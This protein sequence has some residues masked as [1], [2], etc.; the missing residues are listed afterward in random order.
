MSQQIDTPKV[1][2]SEYREASQTNVQIANERECVIQ[3]S[4]T[5]IEVKL[6]NISATDKIRRDFFYDYQ[7]TFFNMRNKLRFNKD[8]DTKIYDPIS[9]GYHFLDKLSDM[10]LDWYDSRVNSSF[11]RHY[12]DCQAKPHSIL[13]I[14]ETLYHFTILYGYYIEHNAPETFEHQVYEFIDQ[15]KTDKYA[16]IHFLHPKLISQFIIGKGLPQP[17]SKYFTITGLILWN[18]LTDNKNSKLGELCSK[19][20]Q[21][22]DG[23]KLN[24]VEQLYDL[25]APDIIE[26]FD[27]YR[28][29]DGFFE[30]YGFERMNVR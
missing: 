17:K 18:L 29:E 22:T 6:Q 12:H 7:H 10:Y 23:P 11:N 20:S 9:T 24:G 28:H 25:Y 30:K 5:K 13:Q 26:A 21:Y 1:S 3:T 27:D 4:E 14:S 15:T 2:S 8:S 16:A 19:Y